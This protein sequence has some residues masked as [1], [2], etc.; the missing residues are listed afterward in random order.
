M[1]KETFHKMD[2]KLFNSPFFT[3]PEKLLLS[4]NLATKPMYVFYSW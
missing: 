1:S 3:V 4:N 2:E